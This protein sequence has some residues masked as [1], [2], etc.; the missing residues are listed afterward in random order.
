MNMDAMRYRER[1]AIFGVYVC[2][3]V[4][5][6]SAY[7]LVLLLLLLAGNWSQTATGV[8]RIWIE[9]APPQSLWILS[10]YAGNLLFQ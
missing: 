6:F 4:G 5:C 8:R 2:V 10:S 1:Q 3:S 9:G 7:A